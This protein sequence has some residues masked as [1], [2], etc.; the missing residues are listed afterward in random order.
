MATCWDRGTPPRYTNVSVPRLTPE[1]TVRTITSSGPG[2]GSV[3]GRISPEPG[4]RSQYASAR[5]VVT[6][7]TLPQRAV[8]TGPARSV[9]SRLQPG[10]GTNH[11]RS[12]FSDMSVTS[13]RLRAP[14][15]RVG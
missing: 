10:R 2:S 14:E 15:V 13:S 12:G 1:Q 8:L 4:A 9:T 3:T 6:S 5:F 7:V 11:D